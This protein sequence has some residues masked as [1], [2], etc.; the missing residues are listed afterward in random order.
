M[1]ASQTPEFIPTAEQI[2]E[3]ASVI[4]AGWTE[5]ER[6]LRRVV[7]LKPEDAA[8]TVPTCRVARKPR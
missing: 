5:H 1:I 8:W 4:R 7:R 3:A 2:V 6:Q